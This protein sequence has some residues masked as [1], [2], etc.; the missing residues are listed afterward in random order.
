MQ[1]WQLL[2]QREMLTV[3]GVNSTDVAPD[4]VIWIVKDEEALPH[5]RCA[6]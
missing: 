2:H 4:I 1:S 6:L 3:P 5:W